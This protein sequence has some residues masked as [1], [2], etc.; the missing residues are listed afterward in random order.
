M[1]ILGII[2]AVII[3]IEIY[4]IQPYSALKADFKEK[5]DTAA[6]TLQLASDVFT[7]EDIA[8]LPIPVQRFF[9]HCGYLNTPKM[10]YMKAVVEKV[11]FS[12]NRDKKPIKIKYTQYN[13][14]KEPTRFAFIDSSM[15]SIPFQGFDCFHDGNGSMKG[16]IA[17]AFTLFDQ[18]GKEMD[19]A[20]LVTFLSECLFIPNVALQHYITWEEI[21]E[22]HAKASISYAD[23]QAS[24]IF[25]FNEKG[26]MLSF[27]TNDRVAIDFNGN[28]QYV[29]WTAVLDNYKSFN[30]IKQPTT[31]KA[32]WHYPE[33]DYTYFS[34]DNVKIEF[35]Q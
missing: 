16:V 13:F 25:T 8:H 22:T 26:E 10:S 7:E 29:E 11:D 9:I 24:G 32:I 1:L 33:G 17:K 4:F 2:V 6:E 28:K 5:A 23:I 21:D 30:G 31:L 19:K 15:V 12:T 18:R 3:F 34:G 20:S 14:V 27:T 35:L